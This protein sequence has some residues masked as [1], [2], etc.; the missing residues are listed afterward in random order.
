MAL[1]SLS[2]PRIIYQQI[3]S[4]YSFKELDHCHDIL[5]GVLIYT[6]LEQEFV[7]LITK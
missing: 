4:S 2:S 5:D 7:P 6:F 3:D 1:K